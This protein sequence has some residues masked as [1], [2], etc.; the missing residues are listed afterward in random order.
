MRYFIITVTLTNGC[1]EA[2]INM[3]MDDS[4]CTPEGYAQC[5]EEVRD[6]V[7]K[8]SPFFVETIDLKEVSK[9]D[10]AIHLAREEKAGMTRYD[11]VPLADLIADTLP[12]DP[13]KAN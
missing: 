7:E 6:Y 5:K 10:Y 8:A 1:G 13:T 12:T 4:E 3:Q 9:E 11:A 2:I